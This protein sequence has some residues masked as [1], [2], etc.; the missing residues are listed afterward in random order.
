MHRMPTATRALLAGGGMA[1]AFAA[2][3]AADE[4]A[5]AD[6]AVLAGGCANCHGTDGRLERGAGPAIAGKP[7]SVLEAQLL[8]FRAG[9]DP[10]ATIMP[11]LA[12]GFTE[13]ELRALARYFA[14]IER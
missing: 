8:A 14:E 11:R 3:A 2:T 13:D 4:I 12:R 1:L 5:P 7:V 9:E 10:D 6:L